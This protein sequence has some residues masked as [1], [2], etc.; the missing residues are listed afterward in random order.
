MVL[1]IKIYF[2]L[3]WWLIFVMPCIILILKCTADINGIFLSIDLC[4]QYLNKYYDVFKI[5][6]LDTSLL[7]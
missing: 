7:L 6:N 1:N 2:V 4:T 3:V 5:F